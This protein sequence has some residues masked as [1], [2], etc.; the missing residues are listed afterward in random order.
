MDSSLLKSIVAKNMVT[1]GY[2]K[3]ELATKMM[4]SRS[5]FNNRLNEPDSFTIGEF[6]K[7]ALILN[8]NREEKSLIL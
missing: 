3:Q 6:R 7:L 8:F 2:N 4:M 5:T 1:R